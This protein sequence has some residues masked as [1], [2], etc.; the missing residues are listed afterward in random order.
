M[1]ARTDRR[2]SLDPMLALLAPTPDGY[3]TGLEWIVYVSVLVP[4][5]LLAVLWWLGS[6]RTV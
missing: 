2:F 5:V 6:K 4:T 3:G 1:R